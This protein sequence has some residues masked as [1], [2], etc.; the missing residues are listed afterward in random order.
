MVVCKPVKILWLGNLLTEV[1]EIP[2]APQ[3]EWRLIRRV[4]LGVQISTRRLRAKLRGSRLPTAS[5]SAVMAPSPLDAF[6]AH[7]SSLLAPRSSSIPSRLGYAWK[8]MPD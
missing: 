7:R 4:L 6:I 8:L 1:L 3:V 2:G 5:S